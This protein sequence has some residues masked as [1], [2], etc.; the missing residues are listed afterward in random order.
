MRTEEI[1]DLMDNSIWRN[2]L[3]DYMAIDKMRSIAGD[4][5]QYEVIETE[6]GRFIQFENGRLKIIYAS[7]DKLTL[8]D[9]NTTFDILRK[10]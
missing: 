9:G 5:G 7:K 3:G 2:H 4:S 8:S 1:K 10:Q 6:E